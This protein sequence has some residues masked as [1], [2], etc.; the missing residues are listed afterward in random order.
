MSNPLDTS[1]LHPA[2]NG[3]ATPQA[4]SATDGDSPE[5]WIAP[6]AI[7]DPTIS[8]IVPAL[9]EEK[10]IGDMLQIFPREI[11]EK[12]RIELIV[13]DGGSTDKTPEIAREHADIIARHVASRR[14]TIAEGRNLGAEQARGELLVFI[15]ADTI[16]QDGKKFVEGLVEFVERGEAEIVAFA[17]PVHIAPHERG[18][19][20]SLFHNFFNNYVRLLNFIG[21]GM[22]RG[23]C[24]IVRRDAFVAVGGY[25]KHMAAGE[26][27]DLYRRL[28]SKGKIGHQNE[29]RVY[30]SP[31]RFRRFG[32]LRVL[33]EWTLN[34]LAVMILG[35][36]IS[37]EWEE[38]R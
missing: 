30:E 19:S 28:T 33:F 35:R 3:H 23:E 32:Y 10:L 34:A 12:C 7:T 27:F 38:I 17:C 16:P 9:N 4:R 13:S 1:N 20:D 21:L 29:F 26:D 31:R 6:D 8:L 18:W 36:S 15:N 2:T 24:Q 5:V 22:G 14:Q 37:K 11:R 25:E